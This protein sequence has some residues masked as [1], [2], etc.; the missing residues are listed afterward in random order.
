MRNRALAQSRRELQRRRRETACLD[1][2]FGWIVQTNGQQ[3]QSR[4]DLTPGDQPI[5]QAP[6]SLLAVVD[7]MCVERER[8]DKG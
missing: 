1:L 3:G 6:F 4:G 5:T 8:G 2:C 7:G